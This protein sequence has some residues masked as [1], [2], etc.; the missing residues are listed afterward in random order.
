M[1]NFRKRK[2]TPLLN[3]IFSFWKTFKME[4]KNS[5]KSIENRC[6]LSFAQKNENRFE[7][8]TWTS[9]SS[10]VKGKTKSTF[11]TLVSEDKVQH[12]FGKSMMCAGTWKMYHA[13]LS[14]QNYFSVCEAK[15][16]LFYQSVDFISRE[17]HRLDSIC[18]RSCSMDFLGN[19]KTRQILV[20]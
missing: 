20:Y 3:L 17:V 12:N 7:L 13:E 10:T 5:A 11:E 1:G 14:E 6:H 18:E 2:Q 19:E 9:F 15:Q 8:Q 4:N 16:K